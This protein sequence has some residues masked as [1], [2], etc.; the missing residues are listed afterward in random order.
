[1]KARRFR[2]LPAARSS[3]SARPSGKTATAAG[4][5]QPLPLRLFCSA[6]FCSSEL[7]KLRKHRRRS[8]G[9][10]RSHMV[11][12]SVMLIC[13]E[14]LNRIIRVARFCRMVCPVADVAVFLTASGKRTS[15]ADRSRGKKTRSDSLKIHLSQPPN[16]NSRHLKSRTQLPSK[17]CVRILLFVKI[18]ILFKSLRASCIFLQNER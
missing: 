2:F 8:C 6:F 4:G 7:P 3:K 13:H 12:C 5:Y 17:T 14:I 16:S 18:K 11:V 1:M 15:H 10:C 9:R